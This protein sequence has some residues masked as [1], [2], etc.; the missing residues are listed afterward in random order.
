MISIRTVAFPAYSEYVRAVES[1]IGQVGSSALALLA[2]RL[3]VGSVYI[4]GGTPT[5]LSASQVGRLL[6]AVC[7]EFALEPDAEI[8]LEANPESMLASDM[9]EMSQ[10]GINRVSLGVQSFIDSELHVLGRSHSCADTRAAVN[11][12]RSAGIENLS[13]DLIY[14]IP[15]QTL[16]SW[17]QSLEDALSLQPQHLSLYSLTI[18]EGTRL[19]SRIHAGD[20]PEPDP[21]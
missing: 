20:F 7:G 4:G 15:G 8:T 9:Q 21:D 3:P 12:V 17:L 6:D 10:S 2:S 16:S 19:E 5:V 14:G 11:V 13:L 18:E 1:E